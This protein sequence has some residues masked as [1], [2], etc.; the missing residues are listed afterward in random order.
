MNR[1]TVLLVA[2]I[3]LALLG[4]AL[5]FSQH[6]PSTAI[7]PA[8]RLR[9]A[10]SFYPLTYFT[11][12]IAGD[13][14]E[15]V[16]ITPAGAEPHDYEPTS[17]DVALMEQADLIVINGG[18]LEA[19]ADNLRQNLSDR[20]ARIVVA[21]DGLT[22]RQ[23]TEDGTTGTDPHI[24]LNPVLAEQE[25]QKIAAAIIAIDPPNTAYYKQRE[26]SLLARLGQLN[27]DYAS[28][29][30]TCARKDIVTS[31]AAFGYL[32]QQYGLEQVAIAG[33]SPD[34]EP[35]TRQLAQ[36]A[37]FVK[38]H[39]VKY[40]FFESLVSSKLSDTIAAETGAQTLELNPLEGL[41]TQETAQGK[42]YFTVM[43]DNLL[44]LST[45][46]QCNPATTP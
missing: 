17:S 39:N 3:I 34:E 24:W 46:L 41:T 36:V 2:G 26:S 11:S 21:G 19:W 10:A 45:A 12:E 29:L 30:A 27:A 22:T 6:R 20:A 4:S 15:V 31:H 8:A 37:Q 25:V 33:L 43:Q 1:Q 28:T 38:D 18:H 35:S 5:Y 9:I 13:K 40:I 14:A 7:S 16:N 42:N 32:A 44:H 23:L